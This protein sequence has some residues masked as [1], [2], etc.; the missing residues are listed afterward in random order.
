MKK[1]MFFIVI[2]TVAINFGYSQTVYSFNSFSS[3]PSSRYTLAENTDHSLHLSIFIESDATL[4]GFKTTLDGGH[5][6]IWDLTAF[7]KNEWIDLKHDFTTTDELVNP[8]FNI[9]IIDDNTSGTG[10]GTFFI[11]DIKIYDNSSLSIPDI[12]NEVSMTPNPVENVLTLTNIPVNFEIKLYS[13]LGT[14]FTVK[15]IDND[16]G[17]N[18]EMSELSSGVYILKIL[19]ENRTFTR[20]IIKK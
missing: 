8:V 15:K 2:L 19:D 14:E 16:N 9:E 1:I 6:L 11:D 5:E 4:N 7:N 17:V 12:E 18:L 10:F 20:K 13:I 3:V